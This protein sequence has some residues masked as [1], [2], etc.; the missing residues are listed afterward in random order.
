MQLMRNLRLVPRLH[1]GLR[2]IRK[3]RLVPRKKRQEESETSSFMLIYSMGKKF[4]KCYWCGS[5]PWARIIFTGG[6]AA[7]EERS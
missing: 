6:R 7:I 2:L 4:G 3:A 1:P 5:T